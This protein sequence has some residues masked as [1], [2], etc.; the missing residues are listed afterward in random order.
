MVDTAIEA[1]TARMRAGA[2]NTHGVF[3]L[4]EEID[5]LIADARRR[6][7][8]LPRL[9][10][11]R[12]GLR[13]ER[14][15]AAAPSVALDRA[16]VGTGRRDRRHPA[17]PRRQRAAVDARRSRRGRHRAV[18]RRARRRRDARPR[19]VRRGAVGAHEARRVHARVQRRGHD[20]AGC[21]PGRAREGRPARSSRSTASTSPSTARSTCTAWG[22]DIVATSPYKYFGPH[23]GM[24]GGARGAARLARALQA[25]R[26]ARR[27]PRLAGKRARRA[28]R[29]SPARSRRS[30]TS[31]RPGGGADRRAAIRAG[32]APVRG[33]RADAR[34]AVPRRRRGDRRRA[35]ASA[36]PIPS[37]STSARRPS[38]SAWATSTRSR[39]AGA[40][41]ERGIFTWD[42]HYY[43]IEV[44]DRL[45]LL[46]TGGAVRIGFCH[47]HTLDEVDR[48]L[49]AL[50]ELA[51]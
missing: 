20:A 11:G 36:S 49:D 44:F 2:S 45:G 31:P 42:G 32:F 21:R 38:P 4:S 19:L 10:P 26:R 40:L 24:L 7:R 16:D 27:G 3:P 8:R 48:V 46:E 15:V 1:I 23:Q 13:P 30:T 12:G 37:G 47:Y 50:A 39:R 51:G 5:A 28:T 41:A 25:A 34:P 22:A 33:A 17:R 6:G 18:G 9:R 43:A 35:P 29:R 14:D